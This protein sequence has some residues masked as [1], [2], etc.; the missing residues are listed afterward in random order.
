MVSRPPARSGTIID[1]RA[2]IMDLTSDD[3]KKKI[4]PR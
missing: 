2:S 3:S 1:V 4:A